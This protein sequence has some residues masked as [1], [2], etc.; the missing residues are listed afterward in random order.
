M[1]LYRKCDALRCV[2]GK[3]LHQTRVGGVVERE[4]VDGDCP[5][6]HGERYVAVDLAA[7][8]E[9]ISKAICAAKLIRTSCEEQADAVMRAL[10]GGQG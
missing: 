4:W 6:C 9:T 5:T 2:D 3:Q 8:R 10:T 1:T 7:L